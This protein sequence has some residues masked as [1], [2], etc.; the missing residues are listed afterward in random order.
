[1]AKRN[2]KADDKYALISALSNDI[3]LQITRSGE[4]WKAFLTLASRVY[5]YSFED[6][7]L[8][9]AQKP[10][11]TACASAEIWNRAM[12]CWINRGA[13]G[14]ALIDK[15]SPHKLKYVF[16]VSSVHK[17]ESGRF[18]KLWQMQEKHKD[19]VLEHLEALYGS[20]NRELDFTDRIMELSVKAA[21]DYS[22][23]LRVRKILIDSVAYA[24]LRRCDIGEKELIEKI[25]FPY[26]H[27]FAVVSELYQFG[28]NVSEISKNIL[29]EIGRAI[30]K[31]EKEAASKKNNQN[32]IENAGQIDYNTLKRESDVD[33]K[34][35]K[36]EQDDEVR[37]RTM[38]RLPDTEAADGRTAGGDN[39][40]IRTD[41][42]EISSRAQERNLRGTAP[43]WK[44]ER[45]FAHDSGTGRAEDGFP[46]RSDEKE[47]GRDREIES[48]RSDEVG[49]HDEQHQALGGRD[50]TGGDYIQLT[51][52]SNVEEQKNNIAAETVIDNMASAAFILK[53]EKKGF[54]PKA[55]FHQN[56]EAIRILE[57]IESE[58]RTATPEEQKILSQYVGWGGLAD[59]FDGTKANWHSEYQELKGLLSNAEYASARESTLNAH[60]TSHAIISSIYEALDRMGFSKGNILESAMG[61]GNF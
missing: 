61:I 17:S 43:A 4:N 59:V 1:M 36:G 53:E 52:F 16:D 55:R 27:E 29:V 8:I 23:D 38:R 18:P 35:M 31:Y 34:E 19:A 7:I 9:Y 51:L 44:T 24:V 15:T 28:A 25:S 58:N 21:S 14:I 54:A 39:N 20:K 46:D 48:D 26:I 13:K 22:S 60:Y 50:R 57:Q 2:Y 37:V 42:R 40:K 6:Q 47:R 41:A 49:G 12:H 30:Y 3:A 33:H 56:V 11:A 45:A 32:V 5:R 10:D